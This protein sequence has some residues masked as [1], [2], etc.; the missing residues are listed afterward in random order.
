M[1]L[2]P[3]TRLIIKESETF[4]APGIVIFVLT[5]SL[6][7]FD[8][9]YNLVKLNIYLDYIYSLIMSGV[10]LILSF[11]NTLRSVF[12]TVI[13]SEHRKRTVRFRE[14]SS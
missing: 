2:Y 6:I 7:N 1:F 11:S 4:S 5:L 12:Y 3:G 8:V 14:Q 10:H 13:P 9:N